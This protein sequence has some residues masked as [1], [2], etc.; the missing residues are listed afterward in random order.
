MTK[1]I[2]KRPALSQPDL[3]ESI[4]PVLKRVYAARNISSADEIDYSI[5]NLLPFELL[6]NI[7][8]AAKL[9]QSA[10]EKKKRVVIVADYD[11]DGATACALAIRGFRMMGHE[12]VDF[13]VPDRLLHGYG[14]SPAIVELASDMSPDMLITVDNGISSIE[15]VALARTKGIDVLVTDHHL[16]GP[17][18]PDANVIVNPNLKN[19]AFPSKALAGVGVMFYVLAALRSELRGSDWFKNNELE[20]PRLDRLLDLVALGTV[21][22]VVPLDRNNRVLVFQGL[23]RIRRGICSAGVRAL[24][25]VSKRPPE[26][27][28]SAD[29]GFALGPRLNAA[30]R[31]SDMSLGIK[32]LLSDNYSDA[33]RIAAELDQLNRERREIQSDMEEDALM[34]IRHLD[35]KGSDSL[36]AGLC[37]FEEDWHQGVVGIVAS[38]IKEYVNRPVIAF[39]LESAGMLKGSARS[40][41]KIHIR[42]VLEAIATAQPGLIVKFGGH[43]MAAGLS[44]HQEN[45][46]KFCESFESEIA[47]QLARNGVDNDLLSDG[48]LTDKDMSLSLATELRRAGPWGQG[49]PEPC[50]EGFFRLV[51]RKIVGEKHLKLE[52]SPENSERILDA[53]VFNFTDAHWSEMVERVQVLYRLDVNQFHGRTR[54]QLMIDHIEPIDL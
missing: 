1:L 7:R 3:A 16:P 36:P 8:Q 38:R 50:F 45:Y 35:I 52:L 6:K 30:G 25:T 11:S 46:E 26:K 48:S 54:L 32:C 47:T 9:L 4:H 17:E 13:I 10:I 18:L 23:Q 39:A 12:N 20:E 22:D 41:S 27:I 14:L 40:I 53:I 15:G 51:S 33:L 31:L 2:S 42:D 37:L 43:A 44:L 29:L 28:Q 21:A 19:D 5:G 49:F 24:L 34:A